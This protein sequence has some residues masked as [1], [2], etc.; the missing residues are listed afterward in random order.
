MRLH[1]SRQQTRTR[2]RGAE[3][4]IPGLGVATLFLAALSLGP[5][6]AHVLEAGPRLAIWSPELWRETTVFNGQFE[7]FAV[8]GAPV[9]LAAIV[10]TVLLAF[11]LHGRRPSVAL[12]LVGAALFIAALA[13]WFILVAPMNAVLALWAAGPLPADFEAVRHRWEIGHMVV[14]ALKAFGFLFVSAALLL[15]QRLRRDT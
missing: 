13:A 6:Y 3:R 14:A 7:Y 9:D 11:L 8:V 2:A 5:S 15:P 1:E 12:A 4:F 10:C